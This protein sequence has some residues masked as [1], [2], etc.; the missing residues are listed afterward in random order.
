MKKQ[1]NILKGLQVVSI[2]SIGGI[3]AAGL[4][5][6]VSIFGAFVLQPLAIL[7]MIGLFG[8]ADARLNAQ[9]NT[10]SVYP[11]NAKIKSDQPLSVS[12]L[13]GQE[14]QAA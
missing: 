7:T 10:A 4:I 13:D 14:N 8:F 6:P 12:A 3:V 11:L 1:T 9:Q 5:L 2:L